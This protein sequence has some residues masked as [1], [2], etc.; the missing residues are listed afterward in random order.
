MPGRIDLEFKLGTA[1]G[2]RRDVQ[3][4]GERM[5]ILVLGDFTGRASRSVVE[6]ANLA[7]RPIVNVDQD[8]FDAV[9]HSLAP[10]L[11]LDGTN[12]DGVVKFDSHDDFHPD[13]LFARLD[14][15]RALR[16]SRARLLDATTFDAEADRL[17]QDPPG[18]PVERGTPAQPV[19]GDDAQGSLLQRLIGAPASAF[20]ASQSP[21]SKP[22]GS[23]IDD[24]VRR[25]VQ[26]HIKPGATRSAAPFLAALDA[27]SSDVMR[28]LLQQPGFQQLEAA[29]RGL[30]RFVTTVELGDEVELHLLDVS[31]SELQADL[32]TSNDDPATSA[33][34]RRLAQSR[35]A[36]IERPWSLLVGHYSFGANESDL[37]LLQH[38]GA[39][40]SHAGGPLLAAAEASLAGCDRLDEHT[41][42]RDW[43]FADAGIE[44]GW[45][46][47][48]HSPTA[49]W[50]GLALPRI[51]LR[52]PYGKKTDAVDA[53]N[54]E[55]VTATD[56]HEAS[57]WGNP[58]LACAQAIAQAF[59]EQADELTLDGAFDIDDLPA[60]VRDRDGEKQLQACAEYRLPVQVGEGLLQKGLIPL[61]SYG[62]RAAA[63]IVG[64]P[65]IAEPRRGLAGF[66]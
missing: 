62:N 4:L 10:S 51:L 49:A 18:V 23:V 26:P 14:A 21:G 27:S 57:L 8:N 9:L 59:I 58:A 64:L 5:R 52:L 38:L 56:S 32:A 2:T 12:A 48:R 17:L 13:S 44:R 61:L 66:D 37:G 55:E 11:R 46:A 40:A 41:Q 60:Y 22:P 3:P 7:S 39:I 35:V 20:P 43:A 50:I 31:K 47:L 29:W 63:R 33:L 30:R 45:R 36:G 42:P 15:F 34:C 25:L 1:T 6:A 54:F 16:E 19:A 53:F 65:S 28:A 24:L